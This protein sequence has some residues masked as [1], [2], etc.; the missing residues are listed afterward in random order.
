MRVE[1]LERE[2]RAD[3]PEPDQ[4]FTRKL[5]DWAAAGFPRGELDP[6]AGAGK[7]AG[8]GFPGAVRDLWERIASTPPRRIV[9][10]VA[11]A[12]TTRRGRRRRDHPGRRHLGRRRRRPRR[13]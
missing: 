12:A 2:L 5:D 1:D 7:R 13:R 4:E 3:R 6:R 9:A 8:G 10:P 11:A